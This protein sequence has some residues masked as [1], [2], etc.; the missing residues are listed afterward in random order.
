LTH[1]EEINYC[2]TCGMP[3]EKGRS[4]CKGCGV[5]VPSIEKTKKEEPTEAKQTTEHI[6]ETLDEFA[7]DITTTV[8]EAPTNGII[9]ILLGVFGC[10]TGC[11]ILPIVGLRVVKKAKEKNEDP[12]LVNI[13]RILNTVLIVFS[14]FV[15][16]G[17]VLAIVLPLIL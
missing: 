4:Y 14:I 13:A 17:I 1:D 2:R 10:L 11:F 16:V 9:A 15:L 7:S 5:E 6:K 3:L 12:K 8:D